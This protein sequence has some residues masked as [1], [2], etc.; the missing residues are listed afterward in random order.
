M[1]WCPLNRV[2]GSVIGLVAVFLLMLL[3]ATASLLWSVHQ[4]D[5]DDSEGQAQRFVS[6]AESAFNRSLVGVDV[7][8]ASM[9][10]LL[11]L[12]GLQ[13]RQINA[14]STSRVMLGAVQQNLMVRYVA[15]LNPQ[16]HVIASS[17]PSGAALTVHLPAGFINQVLANAVSSLMLS[18]PMVS[19]ASSE[20]VLYFARHIQL[21]DGT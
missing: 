16:G 18:A 11:G 10:D 17:D 5:L 15:L 20:R 2:A 13:A 14:T 19:F 12:S 4:T 6:G 9:D 7:L 1:K 3:L 8:L 21:G